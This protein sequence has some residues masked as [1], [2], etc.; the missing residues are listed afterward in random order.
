MK[1]YLLFIL[2]FAVAV[3]VTA[4]NKIIIKYYDS[5]CWVNATKDSAR[6][7]IVYIDK[8]SVYDCTTFYLPSN[9][10]YSKFIAIDTFPTSFV[11]LKLASGIM[12]SK[13]Q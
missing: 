6:F 10:L 8:D 1:K 4:Q 9:K 11:R 13:D 2:F 7:Y 5:S 12:K 3:S